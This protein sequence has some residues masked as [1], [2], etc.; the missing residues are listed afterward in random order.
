MVEKAFRVR[1]SLGLTVAIASLTSAVAAAG[2]AASGTRPPRGA[3]AARAA[4]VCEPAWVPEFGAVDGTNGRVK[5]MVEYDDGRGPALYLGGEFTFAGGVRTSRIARWDGETFEDVGGGIGGEVEALVV[6][7]DGGGP[8]LYAAGSFTTAGGQPAQRIA[9]WDGMS[10]TALAGGVQDGSVWTL[11]V[12]DAGAGPQLLVGGSFTLVDGVSRSYL[13][14]WDGSTWLGSPGSAQPNSSVHAFVVHD[15]GSGPKLFVGGQF[16]QIGSFQSG[17]LAC[18]NGTSWTR[19]GSGPA[20]NA[21][22][23]LEVF[24]EGAGPVLAAGGIFGVSRWDGV[25]WSPLPFSG[26][27]IPYELAAFDDG[28]GEKLYAGVAFDASVNPSSV[29]RWDGT[30]WVRVGDGIGAGVV[31]C[32]AVYDGGSGRELIAGGSFEQ[33]GAKLL[34]NAARLA[35]STWRPMG[36][37]RSLSGDVRVLATFDDGTGGALY[38]G[39]DFVQVDGQV[40]NRIARWDGA[41]WGSLADGVSGPVKA[42]VVHDDGSGPALYAG[43]SFT[44][45]GGGVV[46]HIARWDGTAWSS[47]GAG[48][49][50]DVDSLAVFDAGSGP[51][52]YAG[53][54]FN[55]AGGVPASRIA[56]WNGASWAPL[57]AGLVAAS[58]ETRVRA[59]AV[60]DDGAGPALY[61]GGQ[62]DSAGGVATSDI[63]RWDGSSWTAVPFP[64]G[65]PS[66]TSRGV[67]ALH[68]HDDGSGPALYAASFYTGAV[69]RWDGSI[70]TPEIG[71]LGV[72]AFAVFDD[73]SG[74]A[75]HVGLDRD[76]SNNVLKRGGASWSPLGVGVEDGGVRTLEVFRGALFA[77]GSFLR[78]LDSGDTFLGRWGSDRE[79]PVIEAPPSVVVVDRFGTPGEVVF[80]EVTAGDGSGTPTLEC[81]PPSG[82]VFPVGTTIVTCTATDDCLNQSSVEFPVT[83]VPRARRR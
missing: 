78:V 24:D 2:Q 56:R 38:A 76:P 13:A 21:V 4:S 23:E 74:P 41:G 60:H 11:A 35:G 22:V 29:V 36:P 71:L 47:L 48:V 14:R 46:N 27:V 49:H 77:G 81:Q 10:W 8:A 83:V 32:L 42:L 59:M 3:L 40:V 82:S 61:V 58:G 70:W 62:F 19:P 79:P 44:Q 51:E 69:A 28:S 43:G 53:G 73:G 25:T 33:R 37:E 80:Y 57:G 31:D 65:V 55:A 16:T 15:D 9:R 26:L 39:G 12:H 18:W 45:A 17:P 6:Y 68:V 7:D 63:A 54:G 72:R 52:L 64:F 66:G 34:V 5:A 67:Y 75:L 50:P 30:R 20:F 1:S